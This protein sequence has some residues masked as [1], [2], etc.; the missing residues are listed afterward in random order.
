MCC[1]K[2]V[3]RL[4][5]LSFKLIKPYLFSSKR[6][7][8]TGTFLLNFYPD[9]HKWKKLR[10]KLKMFLYKKFNHMIRQICWRK[11][12]GKYNTSIS[13]TLWR[14]FVNKF[15]HTWIIL[16]L[17]LLHND[18]SSFLHTKIFEKYVFKIGGNLEI[19]LLSI[20]F[21]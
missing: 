21:F 13:G 11:I 5:V 15:G 8:W 7:L 3:S 16:V 9:K 19:L 1:T 18:L 4:N 6:D 17:C 14:Y 20:G 10:K 12:R 2:S